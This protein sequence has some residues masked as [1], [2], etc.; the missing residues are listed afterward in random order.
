M[1]V[2]S[3]LWTHPRVFLYEMA[4]RSINVGRSSRRPWRWWHDPLTGRPTDVE[5]L[6]SLSYA[7]F[8]RDTLKPALAEVN[9]ITP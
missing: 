8:K 7:V 6:N 3:Q 2:L 9:A 4:C 5:R 1:K